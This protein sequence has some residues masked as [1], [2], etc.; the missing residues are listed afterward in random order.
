M[1]KLF[2]LFFFVQLAFDGLAQGYSGWKDIINGKYIDVIQKLNNDK[3]RDLYRLEERAHALYRSYQIE[4]YHKTIKQA[5]QVDGDRSRAEILIRMR[6]ADYYQMVLRSDSTIH[7]TQEA[8]RLYRKT[9]A[10]LSD[11]LKCYIYSNYAN[12]VRNWRGPDA[13]NG[14]RWPKHIRNQYLMAYLDTAMQFAVNDEQRADIY[15]ILGTLHTD[16]LQAYERDRSEEHIIRSARSISY[17][18]KAV[19]LLRSP[20]R[21]AHAYALIGLNHHYMQK[22]GKA[23]AAYQKAMSWLAKD[24]IIQSAEE[25]LTVCNW[26]GTNLELWFVQSNETD[27]L[28]LAD[29]M[30][31][32]S[33]PYWT[34]MLNVAGDNGVND[35]YRVSPLNKMAAVNY[36]LYRQTGEQRYFERAFEYADA[37][38][39]PTQDVPNVKFA[40][41]QALLNDS[42]AFVHWTITT[43]P[44]VN[45]VFVILKDTAMV[46]QTDRAM[47]HQ[48]VIS[49]MSGQN[50][51]TEFKSWSFE[52]YQRYFMS[53]D[54]VL[55][56][57]GI[58]H[59]VASNC[60]ECAT[61]N[62][63]VLVSDTLSTTWK[64]LAY[65]F[66]RY[67]I[68]YALSARSYVSCH[69]SDRNEAIGIGISI[70]DYTQRADLRF[71]RQ[72]VSNLKESYEVDISDVLDNLLGSTVALLLSHGEGSVVQRKA[73]LFVKDDRTITVDDIF[74]LQLNN[75]LVLVTACNTNTS[76]SYKS[77]GAVG[78]FTKALRYAGSKSTVTTSWE[79]DEQT[80]AFIISRFIHY[81]AAGID[82]STALWYAKNDYWKQE[83]TDDA[84]Y[85]PMYWAPY[86]LT[87]NLTPVL[88]PKKQ[89]WPIS[90]QGVAV[91]SAVLLASML[92]VRKRRFSKQ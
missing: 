7:F 77:E 26:R 49:N 85:R 34:K 21:I 60:D 19:E 82:K 17:L 24:S 14:G 25:Y 27:F 9:G 36:R 48:K 28:Q 22:Y 3:H 76:L 74:G 53:A 68:S 87:G 69:S 16:G 67:S 64:D 84:Y 71:S 41:V 29:S 80:N 54:S 59:L 35:G 30:Y 15:M 58:N 62:L 20:T 88:I 75:D 86:V 39:Y 37:A 51:L 81:L 63:D 91:V 83:H 18:Q 5:Y 57:Y 65:L 79:I 50:G 72:M 78:N 56:R 33:I 52:S 43:R 70:G 55:Q 10:N 73:Q 31:R 23:D 12:N 1:S 32:I 13:A 61:L 42:T 2:V 66:K 11:S 45:L 44:K 8:M 89:R 40:Q 4:E 92:F 38:K 6:T 46:I 47:C 90:A